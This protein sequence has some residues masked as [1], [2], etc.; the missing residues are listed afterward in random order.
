MA[1]WATNTAK[2]T[3]QK[4]YQGGPGRKREVV[5]QNAWGDIPHS[6]ARDYGEMISIRHYI[7]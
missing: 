3:G 2:G 7:G 1:E 5:T 4:H 6:P